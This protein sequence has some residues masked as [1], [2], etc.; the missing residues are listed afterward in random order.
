[1]ARSELIPKCFQFSS[2]SATINLAPKY[3]GYYL[4]MIIY[5]RGNS[6]EKWERLTVG[7]SI[8][9]LSTRKKFPTLIYI[10][11][12]EI[13]FAVRLTNSSLR[14]EEVGPCQLAE[15]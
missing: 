12:F 3:A 5:S 9:E 13:D 4:K 1:M 2:V 7:Q 11:Q 6:N 8:E 15:R 14:Q 10:S